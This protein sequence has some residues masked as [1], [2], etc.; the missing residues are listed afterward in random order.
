MGQEVGA[1]FL[2]YVR[3]R[4]FVHRIRSAKL[5]VPQATNRSEIN[6]YAPSILA[7]RLETRSPRKTLNDRSYG[8]GCTGRPR[9]GIRDNVARAI[10]RVSVSRVPNVTSDTYNVRT[11][12][13]HC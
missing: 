12:R 5:R 11:R 8:G 9:R 3:R 7:D 1:V 6:D 4:C 10:N 13:K 2:G